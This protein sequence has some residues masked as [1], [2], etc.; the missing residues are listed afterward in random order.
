MPPRNSIT[1]P[2]RRYRSHADGSYNSISRNTN[3]K[4]GTT[5]EDVNERGILKPLDAI[6]NNKDRES[7]EKY[8]AENGLGIKNKKASIME[9]T[10]SDNEGDSR[11]VNKSWYQERAK[12]LGYGTFRS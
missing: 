9:V 6:N 8:R 1:K 5:M 11:Y 2:F 12:G 4:L 10:K 3:P 7:F